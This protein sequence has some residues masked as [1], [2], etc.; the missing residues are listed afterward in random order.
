MIVR[1]FVS[2]TIQEYVENFISCGWCDIEETLDIFLKTH[3]FNL[4]QRLGL[5]NELVTRLN[6][7]C[8]NL[9]ST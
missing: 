3:V 9:N 6:G 2:I 8:Y 1:F 7:L 4:V 5:H